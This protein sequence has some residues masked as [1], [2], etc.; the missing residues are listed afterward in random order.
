MDPWSPSLL[1]SQPRPRV[2]SSSLCKISTHQKLFEHLSHYWLLAT[3]ASV[4]GL[5][6]GVWCSS[7]PPALIS[8]LGI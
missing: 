6:T 2:S 5:V 8:L 3:T 4:F 1:A 7:I